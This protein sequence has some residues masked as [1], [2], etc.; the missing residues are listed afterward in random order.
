MKRNIIVCGL[1]SGAILTAMMVTSTAYCYKNENFE[2]NMVVGY[3]VMILAFSLIFVGVK[4]YRDK[5]N[6]GIVSFGE[7]FKIGAYITLIGSTMYVVVWLFEYYLFIPDFMEVYSAHVINQA[8]A[9]GETT[10]EISS[11]TEEMATYKEMYKNPLFV[12]LLTY[13]EVL[14]IGLIVS[15]ISALILKKRLSDN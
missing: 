6:N 3:A 12:V 1:I 9:S 15:A 13:A 10:A 14:P 11:K 8:K 4:N 2:G 5:Y 7:A